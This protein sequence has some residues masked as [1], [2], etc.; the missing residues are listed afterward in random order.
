MKTKKA[1][2]CSLLFYGDYS[3]NTK[4]C[5]CKYYKVNEAG[6][7]H[8]FYRCIFSDEYIP[9]GR[10]CTCKEAQADYIKLLIGCV[11]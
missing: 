5:Q 8:G 9:N 2:H 4:T 1:N 10:G 3:C 11:D 7:L 6:R